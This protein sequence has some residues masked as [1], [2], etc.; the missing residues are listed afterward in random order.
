MAYNN[1]NDDEYIPYVTKLDNNVCSFPILYSKTSKGQIQTWQIFTKDNSYYTIEGLKDGKLT[2]SVPSICIPK[3]VGKKNATNG[4]GQA[5]D[6]A[7]AKFTKKLEKG[8]TEDLK[9]VGVGPSYFEPMLA[10]NFGDYK[11]D[12]DFS[13]PVFVQPKLD[14]LRNIAR[15]SGQ[16]S[17]NGK[18][19]VSF[20]HIYNS[21]KPLFDFNSEYIFD[22]EVYCD[23]FSNDFNKIVSLAKK[24]KPT[25]DDIAESAKHLEYHIYDFASWKDNFSARYNELKKVLRHAKNDRLKLVATYQV[26]S[27]KEIDQY[28]DKFLAD[29]YEGT[30]IR[31]D[32]PYENK[33]S[34]NLLKHKNFDTDEFKILEVLEGTGNKSGMAGSLRCITKNGVVFNSN[35]K[36]NFEFVTDL[37]KRKNEVIGSMATIQYFGI[38]PDGS[39]RFPYCLTIRDYE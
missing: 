25:D 36:A 38:T 33:R 14:G 26:G 30:M 3:N 12:I 23:K 18:I 15:N 17:R 8:Y 4:E 5:Y 32:G 21:L 27:L 24:S 29:G 19:F 1:P 37:L 22:G 28:H 20:P 16:F 9:D 7:L 35:I 13:N 11:E 2:T 39:L 34:Q 6:E 31:L 10:K